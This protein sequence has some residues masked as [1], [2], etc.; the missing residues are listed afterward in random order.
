M[1]SAVESCIFNVSPR[2]LGGVDNNNNA[3]SVKLAPEGGYEGS[4]RDHRGPN[5]AEG[6]VVHVGKGLRLFPSRTQH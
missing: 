2:G 5:E 1:S 4:G 3:D 6:K